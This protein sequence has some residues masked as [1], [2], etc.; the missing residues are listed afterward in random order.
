MKMTKIIGEI[1]ANVPR[2]ATRIA[3]TRLMWIPGERPVS[4]PKNVPVK[5]ARK[6]SRNIFV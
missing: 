1:E 2:D 4:I 6:I 5:K 3:A